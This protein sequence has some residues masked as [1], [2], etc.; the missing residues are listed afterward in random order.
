M[1]E[2]LSITHTCVFIAG[3]ASRLILIGNYFL[4]DTKQLQKR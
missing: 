2:M 3:L 1:A 4:R